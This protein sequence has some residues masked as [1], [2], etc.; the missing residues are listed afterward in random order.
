MLKN[1]IICLTILLLFGFARVPFEASLTEDMREQNILPEKVDQLTREK[2]GQTGAA[3]TLGGMRSLVASLLN[4]RA[5]VEGEKAEWQKLE[6][7]Y[8]LV[9]TLQPHTII[10]WDLGGWQLA[11]N[12]AANVSLNAELPEFER[13]RQAN[14]YIEKGDAF[15]RKGSKLN[16]DDWKLDRELAR[17]WSNPYKKP[18][19]RRAIKHLDDAID[20]PEIIKNDR[21]ILRRAKF[22]ELAKQ[23]LQARA[24]FDFGRELFEESAHHRTPALCATLFALQ[25]ELSLNESEQIPFAVLFSSPV[26]AWQHLSN[27]FN[28]Q[29][30]QKLPAAGVVNKIRQLENQ[31]EIP[32]NQSMINP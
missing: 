4:L 14:L 5:F 9:T 11:Y 16:P 27:Y 29:V 3:V 25:N 18:D 13:E 15:L 12:A 19:P 30:P 8:E 23:P 31:L 28:S 20:S 26:T 17:L 22:R 24:A 6:D 7:T 2:L 21:D 32:R 10:Y 1:F